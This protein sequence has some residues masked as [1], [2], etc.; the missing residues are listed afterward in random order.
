MEIRKKGS[1]GGGVQ[2]SS[3]VFTSLEEWSEDGFGVV[4]IIVNDVDQVGGVHKVRNVLSRS[5]SSV[6]DVSPLLAQF[7]SFILRQSLS[8]ERVANR[9][10]CLPSMP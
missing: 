8:M 4:E 5:R 1:L 10:S 2:E 9:T 3:V 7:E 6:I